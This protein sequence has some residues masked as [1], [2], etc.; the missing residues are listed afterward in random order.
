MMVGGSIFLGYDLVF[1]FL[2]H[3]DET[4][5]RPKVI[6]HLIAMSLI[7]T[8]GGFMATNS[9]RGAFQ[10]FL[11]FGLNLGLLSY[12]AM[13]M[14]TRPNAGQASQLVYYDADVT[15]EEKERLEMQDQLEILTYNM[16]SKPAYGLADV[17]QKFEM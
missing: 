3:H 4:N 2:R 15:K 14:G 8:V 6:D 17:S 1:D 12:W 9:I 7:G 11:F 16:L 5:L 13:T 10:G